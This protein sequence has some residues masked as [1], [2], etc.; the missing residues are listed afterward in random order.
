VQTNVGEDYS[1]D[2]VLQ[3]ACDSV[4]R[5]HCAN[6]RPGGRRSLCCTVC[7]LIANDPTNLFG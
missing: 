2:P 7:M 4:V 6:E 1:V 5:S 3:E